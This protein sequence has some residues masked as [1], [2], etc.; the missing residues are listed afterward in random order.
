MPHTNCNCFRDISEKELQLKFSYLSEED[1]TSLDD[2]FRVSAMY[3]TLQ[4]IHCFAQTYENLPASSVIFK[5]LLKALKCVQVSYMYDFLIKLVG[6]LHIFCAVFFIPR[7][8]Y[9]FFAINCN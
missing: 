2:S 9:I 1:Q 5:P 4:L 6:M 8:A 3:T 7:V